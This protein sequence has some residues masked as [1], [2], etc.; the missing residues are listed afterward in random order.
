MRTTYV[1][2]ADVSSL[3]IEKNTIAFVGSIRLGC[4]TSI[5]ILPGVSP[6]SPP[7]IRFL[8]LC[9]SFFFS[10]PRVDLVILHCSI[11]SWNIKLSAGQ[12]LSS[13]F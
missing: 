2:H 12:S 6:L 7:F 10:C 8:C 9:V 3:F 5:A 13:L 11:L 1:V 4:Y